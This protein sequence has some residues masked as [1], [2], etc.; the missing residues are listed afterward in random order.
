[1]AGIKNGTLYQ[2]MLNISTY[3]FLEGTV[4]T[5]AF[6]KPLLIVGTKNLNRAFNSDSVI[7]ELLPRDKWREPSSTIIEEEA[8]GA[9][10]NADEDYQENIIS[11][12]ERRML[13]AEAVKA[14]SASEEKRLQPT[15]RVVSIV[16]RSWRYYVGQVAPSS[17]SVEDD[18]GNSSKTCFV[19][20]MDKVLPKIRIKTRK[21]KDL[22][23]QRI[24]VTVDS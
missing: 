6:K 11:D 3:N 24:V 10:D 20:L 9:N 13:A 17:V 15:A 23:G 16:R 1:M 12:K 18:A 22:L 5:P 7:V 2:G 14:S 21:A 19:I 4:S 8:I